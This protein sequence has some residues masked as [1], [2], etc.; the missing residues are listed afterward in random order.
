VWRTDGCPAFYSRTSGLPVPHRV[1]SAG[2]VVAVVEA[3]RALG[4]RGGVL[5]VAPIPAAHE[6]PWREVSDVLDAALRDAAAEGVAGP[7]VTPFVLERIGAATAG[8]SVPANLALAEH[9]A[10][11]A[12]EISVEMSR[13]RR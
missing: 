2:D 12:A 6:I 9:N 1:E 10:A 8:R 4:R 5:V 7:A 3:E 13:T 11:V